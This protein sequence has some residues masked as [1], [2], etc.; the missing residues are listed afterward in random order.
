MLNVC[1]LD[2]G[3]SRIEIVAK[4]TP[5]KKKEKRKKRKFDS[6]GCEPRWSRP[7]RIGLSFS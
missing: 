6:N 2:G 3:Q 1:S 5:K 7:I 4:H